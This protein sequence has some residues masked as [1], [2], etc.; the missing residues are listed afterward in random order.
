M[1]EFLCLFSLIKNFIF[2]WKLF[3]FYQFYFLK[4]WERVF[5]FDGFFDNYLDVI[6]VKSMLLIKLF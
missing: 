3:I 2:F 6:S 5:N 1:L 4:V